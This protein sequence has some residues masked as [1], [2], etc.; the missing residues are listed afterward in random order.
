MPATTMKGNL[1][2]P[3][4]QML[5]AG[6]RVSAGIRN[7]SDEQEVW[8]WTN[9]SRLIID[10]AAQ[11]V[12]FAETREDFREQL[13]ARLGAPPGTTK[14]HVYIYCN[15]RNLP[16]R[17]RQHLEDGDI[18]VMDDP[19]FVEYSD[20]NSFPDATELAELALSCQPGMRIMLNESQC[21]DLA[22]IH[23]NFQKHYE[24]S[25]PHGFLLR[26]GKSRPHD[27]SL[28]FVRYDPVQA[29]REMQRP[30]RSPKEAVRR[31]KVTDLEPIR[32]A[33]NAY[34]NEQLS[35][36]ANRAFRRF[37]S[38]G[39]IVRPGDGKYIDDRITE[40][41]PELVKLAQRIGG[42]RF[43]YMKAD[44]K[45]STRY[46][47]TSYP[48]FSLILQLEPTVRL[49]LKSKESGEK[50][51]GQWLEREIAAVKRWRAREDV[52]E[53]KEREQKGRNSQ[54]LLIYSYSKGLFWNGQDRWVGRDE[55]MRYKLEDQ[56]KTA[57]PDE[58]CYFID[59]NSP[60]YINWKEPKEE[61]EP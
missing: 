47:Y 16:W 39:L 43:G 40:A 13:N 27:S 60:N 3:A 31:P 15:D 36:R 45:D 20:D 59:L 53:K 4:Q 7:F 28:A 55:A 35:Q 17:S 25:L 10:A 48:Y 18:L 12:V 42:S 1:F 52:R 34:I 14:L 46:P 9:D 8:R 50:E 51:W 24:A 44:A 19:V 54:T 61:K 49:Y 33:L 6:V 32:T 23:S 56:E 41:I 30:Y 5:W 38:F 11:D 29:S 26:H 57:M 37:G 21:G 2:A 58:S 22:R